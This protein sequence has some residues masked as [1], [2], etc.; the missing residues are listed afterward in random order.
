ML[1]I[2]K[3][4][5]GISE[6]LILAA[7]IRKGISTVFAFPSPRNI[8]KKKKKKTKN[9]ELDTMNS[10]SLLQSIPLPQLASKEKAPYIYYKTGLNFLS[11]SNQYLK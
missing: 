2:L 4:L 7:S 8:K 1:D 3:Y 6:L 9:K 5:W 10:V 11:K